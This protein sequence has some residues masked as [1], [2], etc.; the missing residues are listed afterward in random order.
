MK[1]VTSVILKIS[2]LQ[3]NGLTL[4][5]NQTPVAVCKRSLDLMDPVAMF[6]VIP[7]FAKI[8]P[9]CAWYNPF[10]LNQKLTLYHSQL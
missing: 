5:F 10:S 8:K 3:Q 9:M 1:L 7:I 4:D 6:Q 2:L